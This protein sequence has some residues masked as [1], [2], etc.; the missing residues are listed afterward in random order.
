VA[1]TSR[2]DGDAAAESG[3]AKEAATDDAAAGRNQIQVS[4]GAAAMSRSA[5]QARM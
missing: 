5:A 1:G 2:T 4:R 3:A